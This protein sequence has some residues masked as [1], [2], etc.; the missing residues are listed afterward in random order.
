M[1]APSR[2]HRRS[3]HRGDGA[4]DPATGY[5][6]ISYD[7]D[8]GQHLIASNWPTTCPTPRA[9]RP[10][11]VSGVG[12]WTVSGPLATPATRGRRPSPDAWNGA[13]GLLAGW[14]HA[15]LHR[16]PRGL[17]RGGHRPG[18]PEW[19]CRQSGGPGIPPPPP[20]VSVVTGRRPHHHR[21]VRGGVQKTVTST[22]GWQVDRGLRGGRHQRLPDGRDL[23]SLTDEPARAGTSR[24]TPPPGRL[25]RHLGHLRP[26]RPPG[27]GCGEADRG[28]ASHTCDKRCATASVDPAAWGAEDSQVTR[29]PGGDGARVPQHGHRH[30]PR[31]Q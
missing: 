6:T 13:A 22:G 24:S 23:H 4:Q 11:G 7:G 10:G 8:G 2:P 14:G 19:P 5:W 18:G 29:P 25:G 17:G 26:G 9:A 30:L 1:G 3:P 15:H 31:W 12:D 20:T 21:G 16:D 27:L 28:G